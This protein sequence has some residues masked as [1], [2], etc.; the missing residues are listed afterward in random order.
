MQRCVFLLI[1]S[2]SALTSSDFISI[3]P[4]L[5]S[6]ASTWASHSI[7]NIGFPKSNTPVLSKLL[8]KMALRVTKLVTPSLVL[9]INQTGWLHYQ[10]ELQDSHRQLIF[11]W[12]SRCEHAPLHGHVC[13]VLSLKNFLCC[14]GHPKVIGNDNT[15]H[16]IK[17][18]RNISFCLVQFLGDKGPC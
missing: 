3:H 1:T 5:H 17:Q 2:V 8:S 14:L 6:L 10:P 12:A 11:W 18:W 9:T 4:E 16:I 15:A 13:N 7:T